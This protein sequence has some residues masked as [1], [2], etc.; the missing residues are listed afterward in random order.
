MDTY[1]LTVSGV[2][3]TKAAL[4]LA[5][6]GLDLEL[7]PI[8]V[9]PT[10]RN[11]GRIYRADGEP[12]AFADCE[13]DC[14]RHDDD[15]YFTADENGH[16]TL[17]DVPANEGRVGFAHTGIPFHDPPSVTVR[18]PPGETVHVT[19]GDPNAHEKSSK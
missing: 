17:E 12:C 9:K 19:V 18:V 16:F 13:L 7:E 8:P 6:A 11:V 14:P 1:A 15:R 4:E 2:G 10:G 3:I 5:V